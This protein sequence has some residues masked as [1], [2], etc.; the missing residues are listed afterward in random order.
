MNACSVMSY[1][2]GACQPPLSKGFSSQE[3]WSELPHAPPGDLP[4][5]S[6]ELMSPASPILVGRFFTIKPPGRNPYKKIIIAIISK[7]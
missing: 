3:Y 4:D 6:I 7:I 5:P 2:L 1:S